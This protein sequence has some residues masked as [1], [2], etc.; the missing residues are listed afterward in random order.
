MQYSN[1][2]IGQGA[3]HLFKP[4][5]IHVDPFAHIKDVSKCCFGITTTFLSFLLVESHTTEYMHIKIGPAGFD[6]RI[7]AP[8][9]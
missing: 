9:I 8:G 5:R 6:R 3:D 7:Q 1:G 2:K 4:I